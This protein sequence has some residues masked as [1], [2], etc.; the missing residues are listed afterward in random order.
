VQLRLPG[1]PIPASP[2]VT[3]NFR[4]H[5]NTALPAASSCPAAPLVPRKRWVGKPNCGPSAPLGAT[6]T[7]DAQG[8]VCCGAS[9]GTAT[10]RCPGGNETLPS[11]ASDG[12][13]VFGSNTT[14]IQPGGCYE[15]VPWL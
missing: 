8:Y 3:A 13:G 10:A 14:L 15:P 4:I 2:S 11:C 5:T 12:L 7:C 9:G 1:Q 6:V